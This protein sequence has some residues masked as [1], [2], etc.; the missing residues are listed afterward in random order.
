MIRNYKGIPLL[1]LLLLQTMHHLVQFHLALQ[2]GPVRLAFCSKMIK[3][4]GLRQQF[5]GWGENLIM[6]DLKRLKH[7]A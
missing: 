5:S 3:R 1:I 7:L 4:L 2:K 6:L